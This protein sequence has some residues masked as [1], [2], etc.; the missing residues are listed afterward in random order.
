MTDIKPALPS[1]ALITQYITALRA[2]DNSAMQSLRSPRFALDWVHN[3]AVANPPS[4]HEVANQF[5]SVWFSAFPE[6]DHDVTRTVAAENVPAPTHDHRHRG[7]GGGHL[8]C[9]RVTEELLPAEVHWLPV[10]AMA[11]LLV[12]IGLMVRTIQVSEADRQMHR[13]AAKPCS[14]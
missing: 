8:E 14:G 10:G 2:H 3:D 1:L 5:W 13:S 4:T 6:M 9:G 11:V 12:S 7:R